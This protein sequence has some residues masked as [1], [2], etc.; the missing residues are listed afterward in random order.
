MVSSRTGFASS[1]S[2]PPVGRRA[3]AAYHEF[4]ADR[5]VWASINA[6]F[7]SQSFQI[8]EINSLLDDVDKFDPIA[9]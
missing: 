4:K 2:R 8:S 1:S 5:I 3:V 6:R 7:R 9:V